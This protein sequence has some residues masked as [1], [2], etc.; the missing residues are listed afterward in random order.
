MKIRYSR[1][2]KQTMHDLLMNGMP[3]A[4]KCLMKTDEIVAY[5]MLIIGATRGE[6]PLDCSVEFLT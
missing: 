4:A 6:G 3:N 1:E 5:Q 2:M